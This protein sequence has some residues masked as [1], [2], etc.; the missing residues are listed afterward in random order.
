MFG[1]E[2]GGRYYGLLC[3]QTRREY[4]SSVREWCEKN[5]AEKKAK[6]STN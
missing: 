4:G 1:I 3:K 5:E 6:Q 2:K